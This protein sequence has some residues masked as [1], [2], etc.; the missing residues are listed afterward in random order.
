MAQRYK[1][2]EILIH[3]N[4]NVT[5]IYNVIDGACCNSDSVIICLLH[6]EAYVEC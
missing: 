1:L 3:E 4:N 5:E 2:E 6:K